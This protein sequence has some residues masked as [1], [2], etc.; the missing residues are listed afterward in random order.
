MEKSK[1][2]LPFILLVPLAIFIIIT[3]FPV[4][5]PYGGISLPLDR[6][7]VLEKARR[8]MDSLKLAKGDLWPEVFLNAN[9]PLLKQAQ[10]MTGISAANSIIRDSIPVYQWKIRWRKDK[11]F[12]L[13]FGSEENSKKELTEKIEN[14]IRG[15]ITLLFDTRGTLLEYTRN[16][17]DTLQLP[18]LS[19]L[20][21]KRFAVEFLNTYSSSTFTVDT[22][23]V[24]SEKVT[25]QLRRTDYEY[26][27]R[28]PSFVLTNPVTIKVKVSGNIITSYE[29]EIGVPE[30]YK[31]SSSESL[32]GIIFVILMICGGILIVIIAVKRIRS[33]EMGF[34]QALVMGC[35]VAVGFGIQLYFNVQNSRNAWEIIIP[36]LLVPIFIGGTLVILWAIAESLTREVWREKMIP[37]DLISQGQLLHSKIGWSFVRGISIGMGLFAALL[38]LIWTGNKIT[39]VSISLMD[40]SSIHTF[41]SGAPWVLI[42]SYAIYISCFIFAFALLFLASF[43][44]KYISSRTVLL[45]LAT[46]VLAVISLGNIEPIGAAFA[47]KTIVA[48]LIVLTYY[49][50]DGLTALLALIVYTILPDTAGLLYA[51]NPSYAESGFII[52]FVCS[53]VFAVALL[54]CFRKSTITDFDAI[55]PAFAKHI[56]E[57]Q[58]L[59]QELE[60]ARNVQMS[61]LPKK[62][63]SIPQFDI[64]S[65]CAPALEVGGDY[66][67]FIELGE[68]KLAVAIG[69]VSGKGTQAAF[70]MTLT[71]GFLRA[72]AHVSE[73]PAKVLTQVNH[74]FYE[75]VERGIF[76]SMIYGVF[77]TMKKTLKLARAGHNPV[78]MRKSHAAF[79]QIVNPTGLALGL[80]AGLKF[81]QSIEEVTIEYQQG[82]LFIFYT[83]GFTEAMNAHREQFGEERLSKAIEQLAS[84]TASK[85]LE[86]VFDEIKS[87][88]GKT[89]QHDDMTIVVIKVKMIDS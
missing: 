13:S 64:A 68:N 26:T 49:R 4:A 20:E 72:L 33:F 67:D 11:E 71:K 45:A 70:F 39:P 78:L 1:H 8:V 2:L 17:S 23:Q 38:I 31:R 58:R 73:S 84:G 47:V 69:D 35:I 50:Y 87:F 57:R 30:I 52:V 22:A 37:F 83:D 9:R 7:E 63:P 42:F 18:S 60:I 89:K 51:G 65:R 59:Q 32:Y 48:F 82:D 16:I 86:G 79:V 34:R 19:P 80:D 43:L 61:F 25:Q 21:A 44:R 6:S 54:L 15:D 74:L 10:K 85:I 62:N 12:R 14:L 36:L 46:L 77:D 55:A 76:I 41:D 56:T 5:H 81:S 66:Y 27:W 75:N 24:V 53:L 29:P 3:L 88:V 40:D 28:S